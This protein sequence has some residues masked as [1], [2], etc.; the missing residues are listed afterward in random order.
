[1][2]K[3]ENIYAGNIFS[4]TSGNNKFMKAIYTVPGYQQF[5]VMSI[6]GDSNTGVKSISSTQFIVVEKGSG[7]LVVSSKK[8]DLKTYPLRGTNSV[9][10]PADVK[11]SIVN[12]G[13]MP[14][15]LMN[16]VS[17]PIYPSNYS[18]DKIE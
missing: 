4:T 1:M 7:V 12:T 8:T 16:I 9:M 3:T 18:Q 10:I 15:K 2:S 6:P 13:N 14:L 5:M 17:P 11:Y